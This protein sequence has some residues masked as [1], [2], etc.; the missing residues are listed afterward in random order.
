MITDGSVGKPAR[1]ISLDVHRGFVM[2]VLVTGFFFMDIVPEVIGTDNVIGAFC[3]YQ[4]SHVSWTGCSLWDLIQP[5]FMFIVGVALPFSYAA[6]KKRGD[7]EPLIMAHT[8]KRIVIL[9]VLGLYLR[10]QGRSHT[11]FTFEDV[12]QQIALGYFFLYL[13][14]GRGIKTQ[15]AVAACV[16]VGYY[17]LF[18]LWPLPAA[19]FDPVATGLPAHWRHLSGYAAHW[20]LGANPAGYFDRWFLNL[21]PRG[22]GPWTFHGGGYATLNFI[23]SFVTMLFGL[24]A[25]ELMKG[26]RSTEAKCRLLVTSG[27]AC[28]AFGFAV[29]G[30]IWPVVDWTW[31]IAP[32]VKRI[33]TPSFTIFSTG[34]VLLSMAFFVYLVDIKGSRK[35]TLPFMVFGANSIAIY[36]MHC[37]FQ[38]YLRDRLDA[39]FQ[40]QHAM[41]DVGYLVAHIASI[42][43]LYYILHWM[44]KKKVFIRV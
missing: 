4:T 35:W 31:S 36:V 19:H 15:F 28:L 37:G 25:G 42:L 33:W 38:N 16:L 20:N 44:Y 10:S 3:H 34:W 5:S 29:D 7:S 41:G 11:Y 22:D 13:L 14:V 40:L 43:V 23:P 12:I 1:L 26:S 30:N 32:I 8:V 6:R 39:H 17:L 24:M 27:L 2:F 9:L 18:A 21:F